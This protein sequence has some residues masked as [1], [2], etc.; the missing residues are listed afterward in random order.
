MDFTDDNLIEFPGPKPEEEKGPEEA[1]VL[2]LSEE[3][4]APPE[5]H[6]WREEL[7]EKLKQYRARRE[8]QAAEDTLGNDA[9]DLELRFPAQAPTPAP[10]P[11]EAFGLLDEKIKKETSPGKKILDETFDLQKGATADPQ[12]PAAAPPPPASF[13]LP[14]SVK[15]IKAQRETYRRPELFQRPLLF[16][17]PPTP[18]RAASEQETSSLPHPAANTWERFLAG[19]ADIWILAFSGAVLASPALGL[20]YKKHWPLHPDPKSIILIS[21]ALILLAIAYL[22]FFSAFN[23]KTVGMSWRRLTLI[24]FGGQTPTRKEIGLRTL[25]YLVSAGSLLLG[26]IWV[27]FDVDA[28]AWHDR[29]SRTYPVSAHSLTPKS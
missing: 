28:L 14:D 19:F 11:E 1:P 15:R 13:Q 10:I 5:N 7:N 20:A 12:E 29:I 17:A 22:F 26:F 6:P 24:N 2:E 8:N 23:G 3:H 18:R 21:F 27:F 25:G 16:E 9:A 4:S